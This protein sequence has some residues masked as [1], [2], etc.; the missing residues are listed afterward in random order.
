MTE[1]IFSNSAKRH[2]VS[3]VIAFLLWFCIT[4]LCDW[5]IRLTPLSQP[6]RC[7]T[8]TNRALLARVLPHLAPIKPGL[9]VRRKH[10]HKH[11]HKRKDVYTRDNYKH[12]VT[13]RTQAQKYKK[14][15]QSREI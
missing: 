4:T 7:K 9:H 13:Y 8:K 14:L 5:L 15:G 10:K 2:L 12:K 1:S 6:I 3:K 11:K